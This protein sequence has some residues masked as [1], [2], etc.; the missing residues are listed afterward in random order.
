MHTLEQALLK[1]AEA[2]AHVEQAVRDMRAE[3]AGFRVEMANLAGQVQT[4]RV[5]TRDMVEA[6]HKR[7]D[8]YEQKFDRLV[9][10]VETLARGLSK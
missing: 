2:A 1:T 3:G 10:A 5:I 6:V 4:E 9:L 8:A 7:M